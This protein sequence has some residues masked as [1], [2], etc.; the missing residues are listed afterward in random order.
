VLHLEQSGEIRGTKFEDLDRDGTW[1]KDGAGAEPGLPGVTVYIDENANGRPDPGEPQTVTLDDDPAT[2]DVDETGTYVFAGVASGTYVVAEEVPDGYEQTYPRPTYDGVDLVSLTDDGLQGDNDSWGPTAISADGRYVMFQSWSGNLVPGDP[3]GNHFYV[4]DLIAGTTDCV[5]VDS[6]E[7]LGH[8]GGSNNWPIDLS[9]D[10][11][12]A[13]Y[14]CAAPD[15][16]PND[17]NNKNDVFLRDRLLGITQ[18]VSLA[19]DGSEGDGDSLGGSV[20]D[21]GRYVAF[22]SSATNLAAD[23]TNGQH[24]V[25]LYDRQLGQLRLVSANPSGVPAGGASRYPVVSGDGRY[26]VFQ[27]DAND[28][29]SDDGPWT[30]VFLYDVQAGTLEVAGLD[31]SG[32]VPL[33]QNYWP[34]IS[35]DGRFLAFQSNAAIFPGDTNGKSDV[36]LR[37]RQTGEVWWASQAHDGSAANDYSL[38]SRISPDGHYVTFVSDGNNLVPD[39]TNAA[40]DVFLYGLT[41]ETLRRASRTWAGGQVT[42]PSDEPSV[43]AGGIYVAFDSGSNNVVPGDDNGESDVFRASFDAPGT[44]TVT[45]SPGQ[46]VENVDFGNYSLAAQVVDRHVFYNNSAWDGNDSGANANDDNA[47]HPAP[48]ISDPTHPGK[49]LG[50]QALLPGETASFVNYTSYF[51]GINGVMIDFDDLS[52]VPTVDDFEFKVGNDNDPTGWA[53]APGPVEIALRQDVD[54]DGDGTPDVD[55]VTIIWED[56]Y[57]PGGSPP[58]QWAVNPNGIGNQWLQVR[59]LAA[60]STGVAEDDVFYFGNAIGECGN[61]AGDAIVNATDEI[62]A[63]MHPHWFLDPAPVYDPD[64]FNRDQRVDATDQIHARFNQTYF[65]TDLNLITVPS[66]PLGARTA[67]DGE[68]SATMPSSVQLDRLAPCDAAFSELGSERE[69]LAAAA[70]PRARPVDVSWLDAF[71]LPTTQG[72]SSKIAAPAQTAVEKLLTTL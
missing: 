57:V 23:D 21:D 42:G 9:S 52:V 32:A 14:A 4:R 62:D 31:A 40:R 26:V 58:Y 49:E 7:Q 67:A 59:V 34:S 53:D 20:S 1:D 55:R 46:T 3:S 51:R 64:D 27:S 19:N 45:V 22:T 6:D 15:L 72:R 63:R 47:I 17:T 5:S 12:F 65:L 50:K 60:G 24:D 16:V 69:R 18:R 36:F 68:T 37:D 44:H 61:S 30:D 48:P 13:V 25:F 8:P 54:V 2:P 35:A 66:A 29:V 71:D 56:Y 11:R 43:S 41:D 38:R 28:L 39:D 33:G 70:L 10:G